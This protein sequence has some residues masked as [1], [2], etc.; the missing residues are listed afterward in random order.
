MKHF[1]PF[2]CLSLVTLLAGCGGSKEPAVTEPQ[3]TEAELSTALAEYAGLSV[4]ALQGNVEAMELGHWIFNQNCS[5]CHQADATGRIGVPDLTDNHWLFEG[6]EDS[7][8]QTITTGRLGVM[9]EFGSLIGEV[10]LGMLVSYVQYLAEP[11]EMSP[12]QAS[13]QPIYEQHCVICHAADGSG[14]ANLGPSLID[15]AWQWGSNMIQIRSSITVGRN[16]ECPAHVD[17]L[18]ADQ[19]HLLT[20][21]VMSLSAG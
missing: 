11:G 19:I 7:I 10:E 12:T 20:A 8:R 5:S 21:Y 14:L 13:G 15:G 18:S 4:A 16:A 9:P 2:L 1:L 6:T 3:L 17:I